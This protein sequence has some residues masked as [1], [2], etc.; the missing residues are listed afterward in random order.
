MNKK[1]PFQRLLRILQVLSPKISVA[2]Y[3]D[4]QIANTFASK[5]L[6]K[7]IQT[8]GNIFFAIGRPP[9]ARR[10][11]SL[12]RFELSLINLANAIT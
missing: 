6:N 12:Q 2:Q 8:N 3:V 10:F 5:T 1:E 9:P 4:A 7:L 11:S